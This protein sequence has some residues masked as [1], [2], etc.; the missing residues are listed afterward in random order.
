MGNFFSFLRASH[1]AGV[2]LRRL[3]DGVYLAWFPRHGLT[4]AKH[5]GNDHELRLLRTL[6]ARPEYFVR[7]L[8]VA[9]TAQETGSEAMYDDNRGALL[10]MEGWAH[11]LQSYHA[12][13]KTRRWRMWLRQLGAALRCLHEEFRL[14]HGDVKPANV[15][16]DPASQRL[17]LCDFGATCKFG[18]SRSRELTMGYAHP[19]RLIRGTALACNDVWGFGM[20][21]CKVLSDSLESG[22]KIESRRHSGSQDM[23]FVWFCCRYEQRDTPTLA[24]VLN[25]GWWDESREEATL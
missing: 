23:R 2:P 9:G 10:L 8:G 22:L 7:L 13:N 16:V 12:Q 17:V 1:Y 24:E 11:T 19:D 20:T 5:R 14:E 3:K 21:A 25:H 18:E 15:L 4:I 6:Q